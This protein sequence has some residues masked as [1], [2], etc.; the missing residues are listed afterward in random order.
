MLR[1][2]RKKSD[3][4]GEM[5]RTLQTFYEA[6]L[7]IAFSIVLYHL[8]IIRFRFS[9]LTMIFPLLF[10]WFSIRI[11]FPWHPG[12]EVNTDLYYVSK[13]WYMTA[14][15]LIHGRKLWYFLM[16]FFFPGPFFLLFLFSQKWKYHG[17]PK[18]I[19]CWVDIDPPCSRFFRLGKV[20]K[21]A[22]PASI[23]RLDQ[24][25]TGS[26]AIRQCI[27]LV[28]TSPKNLELGRSFGRC[29]PNKEP[30]N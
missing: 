26:P 4:Q 28:S 3:S 8:F 20:L 7:L 24:Y 1:D 22:R 2:F 27:N 30:L 29:R 17:R 14:K 15:A 25:D 21:T 12:Y 18:K 16:A 11:F 19:H 5:F 9:G 23:C 13:L 6:S 10:A